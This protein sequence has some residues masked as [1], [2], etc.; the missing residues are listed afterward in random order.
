MVIVFKRKEKKAQPKKDP[1]QHKYKIIIYWRPVD[2]F[3]TIKFTNMQQQQQSINSIQVLII[4]FLTFC[5]I[6]V[7][8]KLFQTS[9]NSSQNV[10]VML[11]ILYVLCSN[12]SKLPQCDTKFSVKLSFHL[13][14][15]MCYC[16]VL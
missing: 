13:C 4:C 16:S 5:S 15:V 14:D 2:N 10:L 11:M 12:V 3:M 7:C 8:S 9:F 1:H 6:N